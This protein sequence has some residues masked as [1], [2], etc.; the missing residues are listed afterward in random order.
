MRVRASNRKTSCPL[1]LVNADVCNHSR[2]FQIEWCSFTTRFALD[3]EIILAGPLGRTP[4]G[5]EDARGHELY[6]C[7]PSDLPRP[8][9]SGQY[10]RF[11]MERGEWWPYR[12]EIDIPGD[13][14]M[15]W[16]SS[17]CHCMIAENV[18]SLMMVVGCLLRNDFLKARTA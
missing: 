13:D 8:F 1:E 16:D 11:L 6:L 17:D 5:G 7:Q 14:F 15:A 9:L 2:D 3:N 4:P 18:R 10:I 12:I